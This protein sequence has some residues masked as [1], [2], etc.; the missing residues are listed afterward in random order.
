MYIIQI[1]AITMPSPS[2]PSPSKGSW[3]GTDGSGNKS[4]MGRA[5]SAR[6]KPQG[7]SRDGREHSQGC[8]RGMWTCWSALPHGS[9]VQ[10][11]TGKLI[12]GDSSAF[13]AFWWFWRPLQNSHSPC[14]IPLVSKML[15]SS[16]RSCPMLLPVLGTFDSC[17]IS[18]F[19]QWAMG[20]VPELEELQGSKQTWVIWNQA[21][22]PL[23]SSAAPDNR[24]QLFQNRPRTPE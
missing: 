17:S 9:A 15:P 8:S 1:L 13:F 20:C 14:L 3:L 10:H 19:C 16:A 6:G 4:R 24:I 21:Q 5:G 23:L 12:L 2:L 18:L 7:L 22:P 11:R